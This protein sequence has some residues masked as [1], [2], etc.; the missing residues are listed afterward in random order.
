VV[1]CWNTSRKCRPCAKGN[2]PPYTPK[3]DNHALR[4]AEVCYRGRNQ[5]RSAKAKVEEMRNKIEVK[6][7]IHVTWNRH[8]SLIEIDEFPV[9][10][11]MGRGFEIMVCAECGYP[12]AS[13]S[14]RFKTGK[15]KSWYCIY[16]QK[17][18]KGGSTNTVKWVITKEAQRERM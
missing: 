5:Q 2:P 4:Y 12:V 10:M 9:T 6:Q 11:E 16:D 13:G 15:R 3:R 14:F 18:L 8:P 1:T 7:Q 17:F